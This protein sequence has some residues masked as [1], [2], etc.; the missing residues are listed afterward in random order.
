M[1]VCASARVEQKFLLRACM[2]YNF[3]Q[4]K[5]AAEPHRAI[6]ER[7]E[8]G[9]ESLE[10]EEHGSRPQ[11][12]DNQVLKTVIDWIHT[13]PPE[14]WQHMLAART[15]PSMSICWQLARRTGAENGYRVLLDVMKS[16]RGSNNQIY[17]HLLLLSSNPFKWK[18]SKILSYNKLLI[19]F[20]FQLHFHGDRRMSF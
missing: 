12:V 9:N 18:T 14:N 8:N 5:S 11:I 15:L 1:S 10:D 13:K 6:P 2:W 16:P 19:S 4:E 17:R 20:I 3:E 7:F